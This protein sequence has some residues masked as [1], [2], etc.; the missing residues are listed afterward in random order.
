[1]ENGDFREVSRQTPGKTSD[2][3]TVQTDVMRCEPRQGEWG[4][5]E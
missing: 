2:K 1:M 5:K 4:R 3:I